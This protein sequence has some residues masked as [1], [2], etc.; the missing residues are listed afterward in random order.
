MSTAWPA[1]LPGGDNIARP[2][3]A[4][5][6]SE[7]RELATLAGLPWMDDPSNADTRQLRN[8]IRLQL[9][10]HLE[11]EFNPA[12]RR[13]LA[14]AARAISEANL[15]DP[16]NAVNSSTV[17]GGSR[18]GC[19][20][21]MGPERRCDRCAPWCAASETDTDSIGASRSGSGRWCVVLPERP[22]SPVAFGSSVRVPGFRSSHRSHQIEDPSIDQVNWV[23]NPIG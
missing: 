22:S 20:W 21:A 6:R 12:V 17:G 23:D 1:S 18:P 7:T 16:A 3:L 5:T 2:L 10:P 9:I 11:A 19:L 4:V 14:V 13:H 8:R 15:V